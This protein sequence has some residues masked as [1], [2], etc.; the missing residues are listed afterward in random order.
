MN[1]PLFLS[2]LGFTLLLAASI[3]GVSCTQAANPVSAPDTRP[4]TTDLPSGAVYIVESSNAVSIAIVT[5]LGM[6]GASSLAFCFAILLQKRQ[7]RFKLRQQHIQEKH[8]IYHDLCA[9]AISVAQFEQ[10]FYE[11]RIQEHRAIVTVAYDPPNRDYNVAS[12]MAWARTVP[13]FLHLATEARGRLQGI[14][15]RIE[16]H[17]HITPSVKSA[18]SGVHNAKRF[19]IGFDSEKIKILPPPEALT[20]AEAWYKHKMGEVATWVV[21]TYKDPL[22]RIVKHIEPQLTGL[23]DSSP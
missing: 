6:L 13:Q 20:K 16:L 8:A 12:A 22:E 7:Q 3:A 14:L 4:A 10:S 5:V 11:A 15:A 19:D 21:E 9:T 18:I 1:T 2:A 17:F 23:S